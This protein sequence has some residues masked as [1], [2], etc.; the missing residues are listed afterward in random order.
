MIQ[1]IN[2]SHDVLP[3]YL[4][5]DEKSVKSGE[6]KHQ[7]T[8]T[9]DGLKI[10]QIKDACD[11][12]RLGDEIQLHWT[13]LLLKGSMHETK[14]MDDYRHHY[15]TVETIMNYY[16]MNGVPG[17]PRGGRVATD[18]GNGHYRSYSSLEAAESVYGMDYPLLEDI[19]VAIV[20]TPMDE[21]G[22]HT[23]VQY[24]GAEDAEIWLIVDTLYFLNRMKEKVATIFM[25][26]GYVKFSK[27]F[28][29]ERL[30]RDV[31]QAT[32]VDVIV[33]HINHV[34]NDDRKVNLIKCDTEWNSRN[35]SGSKCWY[36][37]GP[38]RFL[39][40]VRF[41]GKDRYFSTS[42]ALNAETIATFL[43]TN[44]YL[45]QKELVKL[46]LKS[47]N[48]EEIK[49]YLMKRLDEA[50]LKTLLAKTSYQSPDSSE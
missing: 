39:V 7:V 44:A 49:K 8:V 19:R 41:V 25:S 33:D 29:G 36:E 26:D 47:D 31:I 42:T 38:N 37:R 17:P 15:E 40:G 14:V 50:G 9:L 4:K 11:E 34:R 12:H 2:V 46:G 5:G 35:R 24:L 1:E 43:H 30:H 3:P 22:G 10:S 32:D 20:D 16:E 27:K 23:I 18:V 45:F 6:N 21:N 13:N 48:N 28:G